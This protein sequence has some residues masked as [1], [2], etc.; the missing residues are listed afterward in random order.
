MTRG[1]IRKTE[2]A[3]KTS[4]PLIRKYNLRQ[5]IHEFAFV[6]LELSLANKQT[7]SEKQNNQIKADWKLKPRNVSAFTRV[8]LTRTTE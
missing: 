5:L 6:E 4:Q 3:L 1:H 7:H 8:D 2:F